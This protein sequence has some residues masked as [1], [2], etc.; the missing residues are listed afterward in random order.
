M[1]SF[2]ALSSVSLHVF[3]ARADALCVGFIDYDNA[4]VYDYDNDSHL[5]NLSKRDCHHDYNYDYDYDYNYDYS[6]V[7][8]EGA[9]HMFLSAPASSWAI[10]PRCV[11][12]LRAEPSA[13]GR[14]QAAAFASIAD[15]FFACD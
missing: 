14:L 4:N 13:S 7:A 10:L 15:V 1:F 2:R 3:P 6:T 5:D 11:W 8:F 12:A 9:L